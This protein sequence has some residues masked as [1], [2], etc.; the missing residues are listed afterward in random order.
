[1][2]CAVTVRERV[3]NSGTE[4]VLEISK[5]VRGLRAPL[6]PQGSVLTLERGELRV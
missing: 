6:H 4:P 1:M 2:K 5:P 3:G